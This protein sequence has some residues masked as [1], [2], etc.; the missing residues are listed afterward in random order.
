MINDNKQ[1]E[2]AVMGERGSSSQHAALY[3][4]PHDDDD[5]SPVILS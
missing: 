4:D 2:S 5:T 3:L 1:A